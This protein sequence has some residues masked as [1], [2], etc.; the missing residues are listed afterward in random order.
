MLVKFQSKW[1]IRIEISIVSFHSAR[2]TK[3]Q[4]NA[5][6]QFDSKS[7]LGTDSLMCTACSPP[8]SPRA[9]IGTGHRPTRSHVTHWPRNTRRSTQHPSVRLE[10]KSRR[11]RKKNQEL[12]LLL[13]D[14]LCRYLLFFD[15]TEENHAAGSACGDDRPSWAA[16]MNGPT[17]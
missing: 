9:D 16:L 12:N 14:M 15:M 2:I 1:S 8:P 5:V 4:N 6:G 7:C 3:Y 17:H 10:L 11:I 13:S